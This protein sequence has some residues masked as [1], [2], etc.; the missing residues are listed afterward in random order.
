VRDFVPLADAGRQVADNDVE[1]EGG[2]R[3]SVWASR[4]SLVLMILR[5]LRFRLSTAFVV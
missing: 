3:F 1:A 4:N 5:R 2:V